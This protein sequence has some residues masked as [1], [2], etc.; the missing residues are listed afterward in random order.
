MMTPRLLH[1]FKERN[2]CFTSSI[3]PVVG[4]SK[5]IVEGFRAHDRAAG[6]EVVSVCIEHDYLCTATLLGNCTCPEVD[7]SKLTRTAR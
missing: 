2:A 7:S 5:P 1:R 3:C 6:G 4:C